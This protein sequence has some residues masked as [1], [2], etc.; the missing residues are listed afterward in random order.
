MPRTCA[1]PALNLAMRRRWPPG[2]ECNG[3][4]KAGDHGLRFKKADGPVAGENPD[5]PET[6]KNSSAVP[7]VTVQPKAGA[8]A[9]GTVREAAGGQ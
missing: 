5:R 7:I 3:R 4:R 2:P 9:G 8:Q 1:H 6:L